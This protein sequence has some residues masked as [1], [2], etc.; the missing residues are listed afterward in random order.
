MM[1]TDLQIFDDQVHFAQLPFVEMDMV[2]FINSTG[3]EIHPLFRKLYNPH[4][5]TGS[6]ELAQVSDVMSLQAI[7][8]ENLDTSTSFLGAAAITLAVATSGSLY[9]IRRDSPNQVSEYDLDRESNPTCR[10]SFS[11]E[12]FVDLYTPFPVQNQTG[13]QVVSPKSDRAGG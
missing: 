10:R 2:D 6:F 4:V 11:A 3:F 5:F 1:R 7:T 13:E 9:L 12:E 8:T